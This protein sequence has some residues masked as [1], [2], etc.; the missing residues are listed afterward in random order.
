[1]KKKLL[2]FMLVICLLL[3]CVFIMSACNN[4]STNP[5]D[6]TKAYLPKSCINYNGKL[7][8][9]VTKDLEEAGFTN[10]EYEI[11]YDLI[12]G[13]LVSDGEIEWIKVNGQTN[14]VSGQ[15]SKSVPI[16]IAYHTFESDKP[17]EPSDPI[18]D[19]Y[20]D[21]YQGSKFKLN[22]IVDFDPNLFFDIYNVDLRI[23]GRK[24]YTL[25]HG[26]DGDFEFD[27]KPGLHKI[28]FSKVDDTTVNGQIELTV[29]SD[30]SVMY[31]IKGHEKNIDLTQQDINLDAYCT[32]AFETNGGEP[33]SSLKVK[34]GTKF[35][36]FSRPEGMPNYEFLGWYENEIAIEYPYI[37]NNNVILNAEWQ[38]I[39]KS[40]YEYAFVQHCGTEWSGKYDI[41]FLFDIDSNRYVYFA[42]NDTYIEE[43]DVDGELASYNQ[44]E[45]IP[46][47]NYLGENDHLYFK[48]N[49]T[50]G[51]YAMYLNRVPS[52]Y[53]YEFATPWKVETELNKIR[54]S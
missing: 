52:N 40:E 46:D 34:K 17:T 54:N 42:T 14:F 48:M 43:G 25:K 33:M 41:Y 30:M 6:P 1:M 8:T 37:A 22:I 38:L 10:I 47:N 39:P 13:W 36:D 26:Q 15:Y 16:V 50:G 35:T 53:D 49:A 27:I 45:L 21:N 7:Y 12:T 19:T 23:D 9:E 5:D 3:P 32:I 31:K 29:N 51:V 4:K 11:I 44:V 2:S 24:F 28:A 18:I 20:D